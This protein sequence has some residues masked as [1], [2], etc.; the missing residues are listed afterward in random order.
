MVKFLVEN[1]LNSLEW[2]MYIGESFRRKLSGLLIKY[3]YLK[4]NITSLKLLPYEEETSN[5]SL[6]IIAK[7]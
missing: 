5:N 4:F 2:Y 3:N 6:I 7:V 1:L